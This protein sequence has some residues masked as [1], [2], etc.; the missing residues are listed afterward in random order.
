MKNENAGRKKMKD[1]LETTM[2]VSMR[3][4]D[5]RFKVNVRMHTVHVGPKLLWS[6]IIK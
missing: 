4:T 1:G 3:A 2:G 6:A 5:T